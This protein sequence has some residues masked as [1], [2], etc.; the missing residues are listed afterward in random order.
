MRKA[1]IL[2]TPMEKDHNRRMSR[3]FSGRKNIR[4]SL[5]HMKRPSLFDNGSSMPLSDDGDD[6][7]NRVCVLFWVL[8]LFSTSHETLIDPRHH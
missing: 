3:L 8:L 2:K 5:A 1:A 6:E 7:V 4:F